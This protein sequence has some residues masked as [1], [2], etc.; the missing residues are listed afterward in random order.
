MA[1]GWWRAS[2]L[3]AAAAAA[4][5]PRGCVCNEDSHRYEVGEEVTLWVNKV[6]PYHNPQETYSYYSLPFCRPDSA[7]VTRH[8]HDGVGAVL[9]GNDMRDSGVHL[10]FREDQDGVVL[11]SVQ[12]T[13]RAEHIF[14]AAVRNNYWYQMYVDEL[15]IWGFVGEEVTPRGGDAPA[16]V[17]AAA[18]AS[19][20][21]R[22]FIYT[23]KRFDVA[24]NG[25]RVVEVN[26][27]SENPQPILA[28]TSLPMTFSVRW[29]A[30]DKAFADRF[31]RYL[32]FA[33]FEHQIHWFSIFNSV[34]MVISLCAL[35][36][37][38]LMRTLRSDYARYT[39]EDEAMEL[40]R[41][42]DESGWKQVHG[43]VFRPPPSL[44]LFAA[45]VGTGHQL[46]VMVFAVVTLAIAGS[47]YVERGAVLS[48]VFGVYALTCAV[49]GWAS[50]RTFKLYGGRKWKRAMLLT[51]VVFPGA[52]FAVVF[53]LN[54]VAIGY[55]ALATISVGTM[56]SMGAVWALVVLPLTVL[57]T[58]LGRKYTKKGDFPCRV[59]KVRRPVPEGAWYTQRSVLALACGVLPFGSIFIEMYYVFSAVWQYKF[60][61]VY[62]FMLLVYAILA[63]VTVCVTIVSTYCQLNA[64][65]WRWPWTAFLSGASTSL[66]VL[67]YSVYYFFTK[68]QMTGLFQVSYYFGYTSIFSLGL[69]IMCG[70]IGYVGSSLFVRRI[71]ANVKGD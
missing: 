6:G 32:D 33:F 38:I 44:A 45:L 2:L 21:A 29:T 22:G 31:D 67:L 14:L 70:T 25:D 41:V 30:T 53:S 43:D 23:H 52:A 18:A 4:C 20:D 60:Y 42:I 34:M 64:E 71:F 24:Y 19:P 35:V 10:R 68:T 50:G 7:K 51:A 59:N 48:T 11:C 17:A 27:T 49:A 66:Y 39:N 56:A 37:L 58:V 16:A 36:V 55:Q 3:L 69:G 8:K 57:G 40:E 63:V 26:L 13:K 15:P 47:L 12:L 28:G 9:E 46:F 65:D 54:F 61:Y 1:R 5:A 62:G